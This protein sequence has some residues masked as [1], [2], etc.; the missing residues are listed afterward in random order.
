MGILKKI[1]SADSV[2]QDVFKLGDELIFTKQE[3]SEFFIEKMKAYEP[4]KIAQRLLMLLVISCFL[5][6]FMAA[7]VFIIAAFW[8]PDAAEVAENIYQ[9][10]THGLGQSASL[11]IGFYFAGGAAEGIIRSIKQKPTSSQK[12]EH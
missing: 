8:Y 11:I 9:Y 4:Y 10:T 3:K 7:L 1:F 12:G 6:G 5:F 2:V